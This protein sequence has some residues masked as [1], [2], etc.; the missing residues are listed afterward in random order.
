MRPFQTSNYLE[1]TSNYS[2]VTDSLR[3]PSSLQCH[4]SRLMWL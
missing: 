3:W 4:F 1:S 2:T